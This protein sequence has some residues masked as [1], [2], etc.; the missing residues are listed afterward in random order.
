MFQYIKQ[1]HKQKHSHIT[2]EIVDAVER[3]PGLY[4]HRNHAK[5]V[6]KLLSED[7]EY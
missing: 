5:E 4:K 6:D 1:Y 3:D 7:I 2:Q